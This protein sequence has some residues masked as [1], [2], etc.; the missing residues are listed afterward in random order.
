MTVAKT[1]E[2][3]REK[4]SERQRK[5][6]KMNRATIKGLAYAKQGFN[7]FTKAT[8]MA[9]IGTPAV[10]TSSTVSPGALVES[11]IRNSASRTQT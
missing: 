5:R 2:R 7:S 3:E 11:W 9:N 8:H 10:E 1:E 6:D 4:I